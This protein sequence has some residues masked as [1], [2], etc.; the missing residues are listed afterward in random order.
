MTLEVGDLILTGLCSRFL[1]V[2]Y[3]ALDLIGSSILSGTPEGVGAILP[4]Q[5]ITAGITGINEMSFPVRQMISKSN[6]KL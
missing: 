6:N 1:L 3:F 2:Y 5:L 4:G